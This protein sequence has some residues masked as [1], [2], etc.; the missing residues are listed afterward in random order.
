MK[1]LR[2][3]LI[4][5]D[6]SNFISDDIYTNLLKS[7]LRQSLRSMPKSTSRAK[8]PK[9]FS[10]SIQTFTFSFELEIDRTGDV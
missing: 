6:K 7:V 9:S 4:L 1:Q 10:I 8:C 5:L 2:I 3:N